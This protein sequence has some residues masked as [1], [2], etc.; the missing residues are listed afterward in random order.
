M[1]IAFIFFK[2]INNVPPLNQS[3]QT[4]TITQERKFSLRTEHNI[5]LNKL[6]LVQYYTEC[7][8]FYWSGHKGE[9]N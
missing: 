5:W 2:V 4:N 8:E 6:S 7:N 9:Y 3:I 1:I